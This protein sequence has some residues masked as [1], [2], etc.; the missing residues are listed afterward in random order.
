MG[1][2]PLHVSLIC[3]KLVGTLPVDLQN[4]QDY[5]DARG[6]M[7]YI[8][9]LSTSSL[10]RLVVDCSYVDQ[11]KRGIFDMRETQQ[12]LM[13]LLNRPDLKSRYGCE[14]TDIQLLMY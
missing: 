12:P 4:D 11:K 6:T 14:H 13:R 1:W 9:V 7:P 5:A 3:S 8:G 10:K 2:A